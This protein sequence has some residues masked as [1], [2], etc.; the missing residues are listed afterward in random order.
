VRQ[1]KEAPKRRR[2]D[3]GVTERTREQDFE[4]LQDFWNQIVSEV[5]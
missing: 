3:E 5:T 1:G 4:G 2:R